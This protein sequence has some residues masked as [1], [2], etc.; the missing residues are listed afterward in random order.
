MSGC[1]QTADYCAVHSYRPRVGEPC[2]HCAAVLLIHELRQTNQA[3]EARITDLDDALGLARRRINALN[4]DNMA[5]QQTHN[6]R[7]QLDAE[8]EARLIDLE[9]AWLVGRKERTT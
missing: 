2:P 7:V 8:W 6:A 9:R 1:V 3:L 5:R 4:Q